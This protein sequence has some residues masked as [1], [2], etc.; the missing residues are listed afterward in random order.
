MNSA[1]SRMDAA[2]AHPHAYDPDRH[3]EYFEG[4]VARRIIAF[5]VDIIILALPLMVLA[6]MIL[7]VGILTLG[8][9]LLLFWL[10]PAV[11][12]IWAL[13]YYGFCFAH[14]SSATI[15][16]RMMDLEMRTWSGERSYFLLGAVHAVLFWISVT[17]LTPLVL[18]VALLNA[19]RRLLHDMVLGTVV[20]NNETRAQ[21]LRASSSRM[22]PGPQPEVL[23]PLR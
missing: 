16:M 15:G 11:A 4:V 2:S 19:R 9:G 21:T 13:A 20:V 12:T 22:P 8:L 3:P 1:D 5:L 17:A 6:L 10:M 7:I 18:L 14:P 23:P